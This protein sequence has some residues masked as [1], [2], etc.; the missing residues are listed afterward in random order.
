MGDKRQLVGEGKTQLLCE[1]YVNIKPPM[2]RIIRESYNVEVSDYTVLNDK[3]LV[4]GT[5]EKTFYY[6]HPHGKKSQSDQNKDG[7]NKEDNKG[8]NPQGEAKKEGENNESTKKEDKNNES[9]KPD[10]FKCLNSWGE[11]VDSYAGIVHFNHQ[12]F[13]FTGTVDIPGV[14]PGDECTV[15]AAVNEYA[16]FAAIGAENNDLIKEGTHAFKIDIALKAT[17]N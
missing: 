3:V 12:V 4:K 14:L 2:S 9:T 10:E 16:P 13:A 6:Q 15:E 17:R 8:D 5:V 11:L 1:T 7:D